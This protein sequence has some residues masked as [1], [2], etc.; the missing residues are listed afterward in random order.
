MDSHFGNFDL[1]IFIPCFLEIME[2]YGSYL[3]FALLFFE[4]DP[5]SHD[6]Q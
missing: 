6:S 1:F 4:D 2:T 3:L 5:Y